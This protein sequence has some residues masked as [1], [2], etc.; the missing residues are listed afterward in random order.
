MII[1][2]DGQLYHTDY[3]SDTLQHFGIKG[4]R[5]GQRLR[6]NYVVSGKAAARAKKHILRLQ[7]RNKRTKMNLAKDI[8][9]N[10]AVVGLTGVAAAARTSNQMRFDRSTKIDRLKAKVNS[11][12]NNTN[13]KDELKK[14]HDG[15]LKRSNPAK[16]AWEKSKKEKGRFN[17]DTHT[18]KLK[19]HAARYRDGADEWRSKVGGRKTTTTEV[20][21]HYNASRLDAKVKKREAKRNGS[22]SNSYEQRKQRRLEKEA[23]DKKGLSKSDKVKYDNLTKKIWDADKNNR[24]KDFDNLWAKRSKLVSNKK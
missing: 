18:A 20:M 11:N 22:D 14:I 1:I 5:W 21:G 3:H 6:G 9:R 23:S 17:Y 13:Y 24:A 10:V 16:E 19:Y 7:N 15:Y 12:K 4:M 2:E 8:A